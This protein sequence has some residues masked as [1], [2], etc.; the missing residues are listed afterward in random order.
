MTSLSWFLARFFGALLKK[1]SI[2]MVPTILLETS[3]IVSIFYFILFIFRFPYIPWFLY[4]KILKALF[5]LNTVQYP[6]FYGPTWDGSPQP[7]AATKHS[8]LRHDM[9]RMGRRKNGG[10][11]DVKCLKTSVVSW[12]F[13][14]SDLIF[15]P[16][17]WD[18]FF[19]CSTMS[20]CFALLH[21]SRSA[22]MV[23]MNMYPQ[24]IE[25]CGC[26]YGCNCK[27][28]FFPAH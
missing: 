26:F 20:L 1:Y 4:L 28:M 16:E 17:P 2:I 14:V 8:L 21:C 27:D 5:S 15:L 9:G 13:Q 6:S 23:Q 3:L 12:R 11:N 18:L 22:K 10:S 7:T 24:N 25:N 19:S